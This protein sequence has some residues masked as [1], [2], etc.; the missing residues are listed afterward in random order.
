MNNSS[1]EKLS[2]V[3]SA[4]VTPEDYNLCKRIV[5]KCITTEFYRTSI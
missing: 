3:V 4:K 1:I 5:V 2:K